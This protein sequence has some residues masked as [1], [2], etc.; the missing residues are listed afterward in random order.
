MLLLQGGVLLVARCRDGARAAWIAF[1]FR[2]PYRCYANV[3]M[4]FVQFRVLVTCCRYLSR[5]SPQVK[6]VNEL[7]FRLSGVCIFQNHLETKWS[8]H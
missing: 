8:T 5:A 3:D 6:L 2:S 1:M 7:D 4:V